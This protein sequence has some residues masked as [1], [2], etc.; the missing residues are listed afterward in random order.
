ML[1]YFIPAKCNEIIL[2]HS[3]ITCYAQ[4][5][6]QR[7]LA[8]KHSSVSGAIPIH[9]EPIK[10]KW[11]AREPYLSRSVISPLLIL[12]LYFVLFFHSFIFSFIYL[13]Y[14]SLY[15]SQVLCLSDCHFL[16]VFCFCE[17]PL[18]LSPVRLWDYGFLEVKERMK[19][20]I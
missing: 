6:Q 11:E 9:I 18:W 10:N 19:K 8:K 5:W 15:V 4:H 16:T 7:A 1:C 3:F 14:V 12:L 20:K 2:T 17:G 13:F